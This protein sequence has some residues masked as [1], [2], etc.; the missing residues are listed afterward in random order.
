[1]G[2]KK[3]AIEICTVGILATG[4]SVAAVLYLADGNDR[5]VYVEQSEEEGEETEE[6]IE[7]KNGS[8]QEGEKPGEEITEQFSQE[9][10]EER[11]ETA[12]GEEVEKSS[13][14]DFDGDG[15]VHDKEYETDEFKELEQFAG[16]VDEFIK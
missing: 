1:M 2:F 5:E 15:T 14:E 11:I 7:K 4:V 3:I 6:S 9:E 8:E 10:L 16:E 12:C 13:Y